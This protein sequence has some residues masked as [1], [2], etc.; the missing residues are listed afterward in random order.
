M[1][2]QKLKSK[3]RFLEENLKLDITKMKMT[4][5]VL[6]SVATEN[7]SRKPKG[8]WGLIFSKLGLQELGLFF[9]SVYLIVLRLFLNLVEVGMIIFGDPAKSFNLLYKQHGLSA[10]PIPY[11]TFKTK[12]KHAKVFSLA[13]ITTIILVTA[14]SSLLVNLMIGPIEKTLA[15]TYYW[16]QASWS[17]GADTVNSAD[18]STDQSGWTKY[19]SKDAGITDGASLTVATVSNSWDDSSTFDTFDDPSTDDETSLSV[20]ASSVT[21]LKPDTAACSASSECENS[22]CG[23]V[24]GS[25]GCGG[26]TTVNYGGKTYN[27]VGIGCQCWLKENLNIGTKCTT[28]TCQADNAQ[29]DK[30]CY[31]NL[32][33]NCDTYGGLY[34]WDEAMQYTT[35]AGAQGICPTGWHIPTD[36]EYKT[37]VESQATPGCES[38]T[39]WQC[40]PA[41]TALKSGGA[42]GFEGLLA[43]NGGDDGYGNLSFS[44]QG[45]YGYFWSS[46]EN[47]TASAW[48]RALISSLSTVGRYTYGKTSGFS[49]RCIK[50]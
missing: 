33:S 12:Q 16:T 7:K 5:Q 50:D 48:Y 42:S 44:T 49:V 22:C 18:H 25:G 21:L 38:S 43:G 41:G 30:W 39:G 34:D 32:D 10:C 29:I 31:N 6:G 8:F 24:C 36:A 26:V 1:F 15:A 11:A 40:D 19:Y 47:S 4:E 17:G 14:M 37:L 45:F 9:R 2:Y 27:T 13:G 23:G 28:Y 3:V 46:A 20:A 35:T